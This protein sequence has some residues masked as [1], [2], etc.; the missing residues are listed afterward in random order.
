VPV[1]VP[2]GRIVSCTDPLGVG[3]C[4]V[5]D[6]GF[7]VATVGPEAQAP[8]PRAI[9]S[10]PTTA[11]HRTPRDHDSLEMLNLMRIY[12]RSLALHLTCS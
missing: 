4:G 7:A 5:V 12:Y 9:P 8:A 3:V 1:P 11:P 6:G 10:N 2:L